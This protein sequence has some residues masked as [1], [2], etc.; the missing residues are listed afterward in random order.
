M[1][2]P[3]FVFSQT[4]EY[5]LKAVYIEKFTNFIT[6]PNSSNN[7]DFFTLGIIGKTKLEEEIIQI[8]SNREINNKTVLIKTLKDYE[9]IKNCNILVIGE[10]GDYELSKILSISS[11]LPIL[12][13]SE[14]KGYCEKGVLINFYTEKNKL[15]FEINETAVLKSPIQISFYL[16]NSAKIINPIK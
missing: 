3:L 14:N 9:E 2:Y 11:E 7:F 4:T 15:R 8:Y 13:I 6:W 12:T 16:F 10:I 1:Q 5:T